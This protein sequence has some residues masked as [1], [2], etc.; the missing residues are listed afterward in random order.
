M[1]TSN[2]GEDPCA[3]LV[4]YFEGSIDQVAS[5]STVTLQL[6]LGSCRTPLVR[7]HQ[8]EPPTAVSPQF[9]DKENLLNDDVGSGGEKVSKEC[10]ATSKLKGC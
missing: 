7:K 10:H 6:Y 3:D 8:V 5:E 4:V 1:V 2:E 9:F